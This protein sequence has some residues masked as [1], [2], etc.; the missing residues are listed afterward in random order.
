MTNNSRKKI[1]GSKQEIMD[2]IGCSKHMFKKYIECGMPARYEDGRWIA[3]AD[4]IDHFFKTYTFV[5]M[6]KELPNIP[7]EA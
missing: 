1:L 7:D 2:Y 4:N 3:H 6:R 5:S